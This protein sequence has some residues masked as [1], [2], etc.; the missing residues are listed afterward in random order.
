MDPGFA[1]PTRNCQFAEGEADKV[2]LQSKQNFIKPYEPGGS[3][4]AHSSKVVEKAVDRCRD[5]GNIVFQIM[6]K[7][8]CHHRPT[9][10]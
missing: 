10:L 1:K 6:L 7:Y 9:R 8:S 3:S 2:M 5:A 4:F